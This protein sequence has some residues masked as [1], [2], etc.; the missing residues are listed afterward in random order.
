MCDIDFFYE[1]MLLKSVFDM[2]GGEVSAALYE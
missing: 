2:I 1:N